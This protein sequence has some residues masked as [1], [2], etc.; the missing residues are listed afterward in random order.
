MSAKILYSIALLTSAV[1]ASGCTFTP[2]AGADAAQVEKSAAVTVGK[3]DHRAG[4]DYALVE[5]N[6]DVLQYVADSTVHSLQGGF[7]GGRGGAPS[8]PLGVGDVVQISV[9]ESQAGGLFIPEDAGSRPG[10]FISLPQQTIGKD[11]TITMPYAGRIRAAGKMPEVVQKE[12]EDILVSRAIE[13]QIVITVVNARS[14]QVAVLGD[15]NTPSK[16]ELTSAG[17][18]VLDV[19]SSAGGLSTPG[20]ETYVTV[21][22]RGKIATVLYDHL[23]NTPAE[24][25]YLAPGDTVLVDRERRTY[26]AFGATGLNGRF[27]FEESDLSLAEAIGKAGGLLDG[28]ADPSSVLLYREAP[29][30]LLSKLGV[31]VTRFAAATVPVIFR[32]NMSDPSTLFAAQRFPMQDKDIIYITN[33][34]SVELTKFLDIVN[35]VSSTAAGLSSDTVTVRDSV[36]SY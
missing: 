22:R 30:Q 31:D 14:A 12:L 21:Q 17:D 33:A 16:I 29:K 32:A 1:L 19:I 24:N 11:G 8:L 10:N 26:L 23:V 34:K 3:K 20:K 18:R 5:L 35:N 7:G 27:D 13:P 4:I 36:R 28:R 9:F 15:V 25:I 2:R 6:G